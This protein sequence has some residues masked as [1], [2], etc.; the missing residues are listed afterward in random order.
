MEFSKIKLSILISILC[1]CVSCNKDTPVDD[2]VDNK[3]NTENKNEIDDKKGQNNKPII[4][5]EEFFF[6]LQQPTTKQLKK[7]RDSFKIYFEGLSNYKIELKGNVR[8]LVVD[9]TSGTVSG[10]GYVTVYYEE[11]KD[12]Y[13][14]HES[15]SIFFIAQEGPK[16]NYKTVKREFYIYRHAELP[17]L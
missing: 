10:K 14:Y 4:P 7:S 12:K 15:S 1:I 17:R 6:V 2:I 13:S 8:G 5:E 16:D 3:H 9:P 11:V